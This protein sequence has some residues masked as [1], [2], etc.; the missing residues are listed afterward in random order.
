MSSRYSL[1]SFTYPFVWIIVCFDIYIL[2]KRVGHW[3]F[4]PVYKKLS[5]IVFIVLCLSFLCK[6]YQRIEAEYRWNDVAY[7]HATNESLAVY[8]SL[9]PILG[10]NPYFLYNLCYRTS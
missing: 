6:L 7:L 5:C 4:T 9:M 3:R 8:K 10:S 1:I 2:L